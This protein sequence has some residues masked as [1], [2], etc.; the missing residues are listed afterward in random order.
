MRIFSGLSRK[1]PADCKSSGAPKSHSQ[2]ASPSG[3]AL[4]QDNIEDLS[5]LVGTSLTARTTHKVSPSVC[6]SE[7]SAGDAAMLSMDDML[8]EADVYWTYGKWHDALMIYQWWLSAAGL[9][10]PFRESDREIQSR[11]ARNAVD[12]AV[13]A[14]DANLCEAILTGLDASEYPQQFLAEQGI[15]ALRADPGNFFLIEFCNRFEASAEEIERIVEKASM[16]DET[17]KEKKDKLWRRN[18]MDANRIAMQQGGSL[19]RITWRFS[20]RGEDLFTHALRQMDDD[21]AMRYADIVTM[22]IVMTD[23]EARIIGNLAGAGLLED[24]A[25]GLDP[26]FNAQIFAAVYDAMRREAL[27][28]PENLGVQVEMLRILHDEGLAQDYALWLL[29]LAMTLFAVRAG[30]ALKKRLLAV[31]KILGPHPV[32]DALSGELSFEK[33]DRLRRQ[34]DAKAPEKVWSKAMPHTDLLREVEAVS[35]K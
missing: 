18:K 5:A 10:A 33:L 19:G 16:R 1:K 8:A 25:G 7:Q 17:P 21:D 12:C 2:A 11:V 30:D 26:Q 6:E 22:P 23:E 31:G 20:D 34:Y 32:W 3:A 35:T 13:Q 28:K 14:R 27:S 15:H 24:D 29:H 4:V 9:G